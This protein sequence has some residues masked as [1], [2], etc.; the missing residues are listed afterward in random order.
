M[1]DRNSDE[2]LEGTEKRVWKA[3]KLVDHMN[4]AYRFLSSEP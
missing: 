4:E 3:F 2:A 1:N